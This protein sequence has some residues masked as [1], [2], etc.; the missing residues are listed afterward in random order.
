MEHSPAAEKR[1]L[2]AEVREARGARPAT[3]IDALAE[4]VAARLE[5]LVDEL[6][7]RRIACFLS[8]PAEPPTRP[9]VAACLR[10]GLAVLLPRPLD[11]GVLQWVEAGEPGSL[12][13][14]RMHPRLRV[15]EAVG[16]ALSGDPLG[17]TDL[18]IAPAALVDRGGFRLGWG[19]GYYDRAL[20]GRTQPVFAL[21]HD[22]EV[23]DRVPREPH[24]RPVDG[25]V[26]PS[27]TLRIGDR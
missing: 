19:G 21:V 26:T 23:V 8:T 10:R 5:A 16:E 24:D 11:G 1:R 15:P 22:D 2:R 27:M 9:F 7:A 3:A 12:L 6:G 25:I 18:V 13:A 14:E 20:A 17:G 4:P